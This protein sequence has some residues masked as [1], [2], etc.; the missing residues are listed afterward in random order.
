MYDSVWRS[1]LCE[2]IIDVLVIVE[3]AF[4]KREENDVQFAI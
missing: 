1:M 3:L 4:K 2:V